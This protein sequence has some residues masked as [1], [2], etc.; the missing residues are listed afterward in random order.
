MWSLLDVAVP[1]ADEQNHHG[2]GKRD[3][4]WHMRW[5]LSS[6]WAS[7]IPFIGSYL[8][9]WVRAEGL[10]T[11]RRVPLGVPPLPLGQINILREVPPVLADTA[12][13]RLHRNRNVWLCV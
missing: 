3:I 10:H 1:A 9:V 5:P 12:F 4:S 6:S 7:N 13:V 11:L 2:F 8:L